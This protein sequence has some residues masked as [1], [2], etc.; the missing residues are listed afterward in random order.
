MLNK[1]PNN[2]PKPCNHGHVYA[3]RFGQIP[4]GVLF[5]NFQQTLSFDRIFEQSRIFTKHHTTQPSPLQFESEHVFP[6]SE[7][8]LTTTH[9]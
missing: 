6:N 7:D 4:A 5:L 8:G 9:C 2:N 3:Q 1:T